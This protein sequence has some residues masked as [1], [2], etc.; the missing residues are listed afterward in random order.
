MAITVVGLGPG[1]YELLTLAAA[2]IL[3]SARV[4]RLRTARHPTVDAFPE[5]IRWTSFDS[6]YD[7]LPDFEAV[8]SGIVDALLAE[9]LGGNDVVYAVPGDPSLGEA[10]VTLLRTRAAEVKVPCLL[11]PDR[12]SVV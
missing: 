6:L 11:V 10:S 2:R 8:Y 1:P 7:R 5:G 3:E 12:K 4:V 9:A